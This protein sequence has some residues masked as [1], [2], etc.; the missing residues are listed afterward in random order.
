M[1]V[2]MTE[3]QWKALSSDDR[4]VL[5]VLD[6]L[7]LVKPKKAVE[8]ITLP[9]LKPYI[10]EKV[11]TCSI[12]KAVSTLYFR[13]TAFPGKSFLTSARIKKEDILPS[14]TIKE[15][16]NSLLIGCPHC[17]KVLIKKSKE[18]LIKDIILLARKRR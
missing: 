4:E 15:G 16:D 17:Y 1:P 6:I 7:D 8:K 18:E 10:L 12:C 13:M 5:K 11:V 9:V 14:D 3:A 2:R